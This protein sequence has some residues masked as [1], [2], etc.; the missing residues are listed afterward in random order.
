MHVLPDARAFPKAVNA[1]LPESRS[2]FPAVISR[3]ELVALALVALLTICVVAVL[4]TAKA[5]FLPVVAAFVVGT[6]LSPAAGFLEQYRI[7]PCHVGRADGEHGGRCWC[8]HCRADFVPRDAM[9]FAA[10]RIGIAAER[11]APCV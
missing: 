6:M 9:E 10:T 2:E 3:A 1:P 8:F 5:F 7:P 4:Y 11:Q